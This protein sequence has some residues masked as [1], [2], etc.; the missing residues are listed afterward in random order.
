MW[1]D[2]IFPLF[3]LF[4]SSDRATTGKSAPRSR[5][6][7]VTYVPEPSFLTEFQILH[8]NPQLRLEYEGIAVPVSNLCFCIEEII[9][10]FKTIEKR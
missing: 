8:F 6:Q 7:D 3:Q 1:F 10:K 9:E 4:L 2:L 5:H